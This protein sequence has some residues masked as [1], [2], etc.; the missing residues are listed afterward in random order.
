[1]NHRIVSRLVRVAVVPILLAVMLPVTT[2]GQD[3]LKTMPGYQQ[4]VKVSREIPGGREARVARRDLECRQ[5]QLRVHPRRQTSPLR[6]R[7]ARPRPR[8]VRRRIPLAAVVA[9]D[10]AARQ[11]SSAADRRRRPTRRTAR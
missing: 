8:S 1:M 11:A 10:A 3:R 2:R 5:R 6:R 4:Y 7:D 9:E